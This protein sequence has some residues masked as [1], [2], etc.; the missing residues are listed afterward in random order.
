MSRE[1]RVEPRVPLVAEV[2][3]RKQ[4]APGELG[5][6]RMLIGSIGNEISL[7]ASPGV[8]MAPNVLSNVASRKSRRIGSR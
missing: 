2:A 8:A 4:F 3:N 5:T 7:P 1:Y 6:E